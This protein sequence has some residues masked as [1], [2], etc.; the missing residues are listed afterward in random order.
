MKELAVLYE[1]YKEEIWAPI[2]AEMPVP[3]SE[4]ENSHWILGSAQM[5]KR[6]NDDFYPTTRVN[7][8]SLQYQQQQD[9]QQ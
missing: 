1:R 9:E 2:A 3:W 6:R 4:V 7:R 5:E 8:P